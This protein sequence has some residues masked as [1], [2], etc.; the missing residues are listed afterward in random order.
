MTDMRRIAARTARGMHARAG[1]LTEV[2]R[3]NPLLAGVAAIGFSVSFQTIAHLARQHHMPGWPVLYPLGIDV[4]ILAMFA[5]A[6]HLIRQRRSDLMPRAIEWAL[7]GFTVYVNVHG[8]P[9]RDWVGA[10]MHAVMPALWVACLELVRH[11][12]VG[13]AREH[14]ESVPLLRWLASPWPT[15]RLWLRKQRDGVR[16]YPLALELE[17]ARLYARDLVRAA[18][19]EHRAVRSSLLRKRIRTGRLPETVRRAVRA[20]LAGD[21][22]PGWEDAVTEWVTAALALP[23]HLAANLENTRAA[24]LAAPRDQSPGMPEA[25]A[26]AM[27]EPEPEPASEARPA[28]RAKRAPEPALKLTA[29][30]SRSMSPD[31]LAE[32]VAAMLEEYG[33]VSL[34]RIKED[35]HVGTDK[36]KAALEIAVRETRGADVVPM[37][38]RA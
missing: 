16:S 21:Y 8:S 9:A 14:G 35:L 12:R 15:L 4:G 17:Q 25:P 2:V 36:A 6:L 1:V 37:E 13:E 22:A 7:S 10:G 29:A 11:R 3:E 19:R 23:A 34:N 27:P 5:E 32:H 24:I 20:S 28:A 33:E 26:P 30:R 31:K 38:R 18:P